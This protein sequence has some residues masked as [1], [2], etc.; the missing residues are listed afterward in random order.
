MQLNC[1]H[2]KA[3]LSLKYSSRHANHRM[4]KR[5]KKK[6][7]IKSHD[8]TIKYV[9]IVLI[10]TRVSHSHCMLYRATKDRENEQKDT[11]N[12]L[13]ALDLLVG[14]FVGP[15]KIYV[16]DSITARISIGRSIVV[17]SS[18]S[19]SISLTRYIAKI[20][21]RAPASFVVNAH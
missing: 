10:E 7:K 16:T 1:K 18:S 5:S 14:I 9:F 17:S 13:H 15:M 6:K 21:E 4:D 3:K 19:I 8:N 2:S 20:P 12:I 11:F